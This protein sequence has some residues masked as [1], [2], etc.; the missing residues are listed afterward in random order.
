LGTGEGLIGWLTGWFIAEFFSLFMLGWASTG[1]WVG[2][3]RRAVCVSVCRSLETQITFKIVP[4][5]SRAQKLFRTL[6]TLFYFVWGGGGRG[7][8]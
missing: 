8:L 2:H 3:G 7:L 4:P 5:N 6:I 1:G